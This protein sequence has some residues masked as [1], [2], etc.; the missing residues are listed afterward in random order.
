[1]VQGISSVWIKLRSFFSFSEFSNE[2]KRLKLWDGLAPRP[3]PLPQLRVH[4]GPE[5]LG[6][7]IVKAAPR[8]KRDPQKD[9][10]MIHDEF[11]FM[12]CVLKRN[13]FTPKN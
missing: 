10:M 4:E 3:H 6:N 13:Q 1:M 5:R 9:D 11:I 12:L 8:S 2:K 7:G